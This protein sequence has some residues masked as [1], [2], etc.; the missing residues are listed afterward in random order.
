MFVSRLSLVHQPGYWLM[1]G[2]TILLL[3]LIPLISGN[4]FPSTELD[5]PAG[6][7][8]GSDFAQGSL[9][10][11]PQPDQDKAGIRF[12]AHSLGTSL[13]FSPTEVTLVRAE[14][15]SSSPRT[16]HLRFIAANPEATIVG[17]NRLPG[18]VN[19]LL[20]NQ[21]AYWQ[22]Q[23]PT[24]AG[25]MVVELY[26]GITLSYEGQSESF[27]SGTGRDRSEPLPSF[28][29]KSTY[30]VAPGADPGQIRWRYEGVINQS[31][32]ATSGDLIVTLPNNSNPQ[33]QF[34]EQ[35]PIAWQMIDGERLPVA[36]RYILTKEG[37]VGFAF[38]QGYNPAYP[39]TIDP[40]LT[41]GTYLG[42]SSHDYGY[43]ITTDTTGNIYVTGYVLST[44]FPTQNPY[45]GVHGGG[46][47]DA[48]VLKL[49]PNGTSLIYA[50]YLGGSGNDRGLGLAVDEFENVY[51]VGDTSSVNFP[52]QNPVQ[53]TFAGGGP[54]EGDAFVAKLNS[55]GSALHYATYLGGK[56]DEIGYDIALDSKEQAYVVGY[57]N[58]T[59]FPTWR[60]IQPDPS[61]PEGLNVFGDAFV[62][63]VIS[64]GG[65]YTWGTSTY[66]GGNDWDEAHGLAIDHQDHVYVTG[67][68]RS[69]NFPVRQPLQ[70]TFGG[71]TGRGDAF[72]TSVISA[73]G[74][75]TW[76]TSTY[77]GGSSND[78]A[79]AIALNPTGIYLTGETSSSDFPVRT[80]WQGVY[81][82]E[83]DAFVTQLITGS[84]VY[85]WGYATFLGGSETDQGQ[86]IAV[87]AE[88]RVYVMG[89][90]GSTDFP[91]TSDALDQDCGSDSTCNNSADVFLSQFDPLGQSLAFS[92]FMGGSATDVGEALALDAANNIYLTGFT[93]SEDFPVSAEALDPFCGVSGE[94]SG[95]LATDLFVTKIDL[96]QQAVERFFRFICRV[97]LKDVSVPSTECA[98]YLITTSVEVGHEPGGLTPRF[99]SEARLYVAQQRGLNSLSVIDTRKMVPW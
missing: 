77:L 98:P 75:Y 17:Q 78:A 71:G 28:L 3:T 26:P 5:L 38:P 53:A 31:L 72:V 43:D 73:S 68:T 21:P 65:V 69:P 93:F 84:G 48:F 90:T 22:T 23:L 51:V 76:G 66:L 39:L 47:Q 42:G 30:L 7:Q 32:M 61:F 20:G 25:L 57:T 80:P 58:S 34:I 81:Q 50:T 74:V 79:N 85:T 11:M 4:S 13:Y 97:V 18:M 56:G 2:G 55:S 24:Y 96:S 46:L 6:S 62:T 36:V 99:R 8:D 35:A 15:S 59:N 86:D 67:H 89:F 92:T 83:Q 52:T 64:A 29:L 37:M 88:G 12:Q 16:V 60:A 94:C 87:D 91:T 14:N 63:S 33:T 95:S 54:F 45:Q 40:T 9:S 10:F 82:G 27:Q 70:A 49:N 41:L 1:L 19:Y 44:D